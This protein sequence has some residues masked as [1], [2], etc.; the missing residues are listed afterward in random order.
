MV[1][2]IAWTMIDGSDR[3]KPLDQFTPSRP[4][5]KWYLLIVAEHFIHLHRL[6]GYYE[7]KKH[8]AHHHYITVWFYLFGGHG[9]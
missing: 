8:S 5:E 7:G 1:F 9:R 2:F 3:N 4:S 6:R